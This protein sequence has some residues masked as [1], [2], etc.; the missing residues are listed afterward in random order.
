MVGLLLGWARR[1]HGPA[2]SGARSLLCTRLLAGILILAG[3]AAAVF[4]VVFWRETARPGMRHYLRGMELMTARYPLEARR[5][6]LRGIQEDPTEYHCYEQL[7]DYLSAVGQFSEAVECYELACHLAPRNGSLFS[8]LATAER[9]RGRR[10][11]AMTAARRA[12]EL[13]PEDADAA[14]EYGLLL[15]ESRNRPAAL[16]M[17]RRAHRLR[18]TDRRYF[19]ALVNTELDSLEFAG[20]EQ[21]LAPYLRAHPQ[22]AD[23]C[24]L[25]AV[26]YNQKPRTPANLSSAID[27]GERALAGMAEDV[28]ACTLL[29]QLYL[30]AGR[31]RDALRV[32]TAG[33]RAAPTA[34]GILRGLADCY[35]QLG[36]RSAAAAVNAEFQKVLAR[37]DR[38]VH[39][40]H[41]MGF[42]HH[43]TTAGLE[44]A[45]LVEV[46][47]RLTQARAYYEQLVRQAPS[48]PRP[49]HA[50]AGFYKRMG[51]LDRAR[52]ALQP[53][54]TP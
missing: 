43:D 29:G 37:R 22:D 12:A 14:G 25:M 38:I 13:M 32:F 17:L 20:V 53:T 7:G 34:E 50:L 41:V 51:E 48:D 35:T 23:A 52:Q 1:A 40:T 21:D 26:V 54:F 44:L 24:Y 42:N 39:L 6:W 2:P 19:L 15:A 47:G 27:F 45:R 18:P 36:D 4:L 10:Q 11:Q 33:R 30:D 5:E 31:P 49:R 16:A 46:D 28:R 3:S 9:R 8:R